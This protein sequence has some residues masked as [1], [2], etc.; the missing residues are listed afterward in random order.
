M[1]PNLIRLS[2]LLISVVQLC[3]FGD[4]V[5]TFHEYRF[6]LWTIPELQPLANGYAPVIT[7][8]SKLAFAY[9]VEQE[10]GPSLGLPNSWVPEHARN[11]FSIYHDGTPAIALYR[12]KSIHTNQDPDLPDIL[13]VRSGSV[14]PSSSLNQDAARLSPLHVTGG[15]FLQTWETSNHI[16]VDIIV[17]STPANPTYSSATSI[18][19]R[20]PRNIEGYGY[21]FCPVTGRLIVRTEG[22]GDSE[23]RIMDFIPPRSFS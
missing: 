20:D 23:V 11:Q 2:H 9:A 10:G 12:V 4:S 21:E 3:V 17:K 1:L 22:P 5:I 8:E 7:Q 6:S 14:Q 18:L 19:W 15:G 16:S 13:P